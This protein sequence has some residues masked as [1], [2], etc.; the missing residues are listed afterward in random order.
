[1]MVLSMVVHPWN[2]RF[3]RA[4]VVLRMVRECSSNAAGPALF[5]SALAHPFRTKIFFVTTRRIYTFTGSLVRAVGRITNA[6][7][8][9]DLPGCSRRDRM[10]GGG[11]RGDGGRIASSASRPSSSVAWLG[12]GRMR[13]FTKNIIY[14]TQRT[15]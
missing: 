10:V 1:M 4:M 8:S 12:S 7:T 5:C 3:V 14:Y 13:A 15:H 11:A 9:T 6:S 2:I